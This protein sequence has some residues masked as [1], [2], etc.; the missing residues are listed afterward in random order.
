LQENSH[1]YPQF[2]ED[3]RHFL[4]VS[5]C[6]TRTNNALYE[7][8]LDSPELKRIM[9]VEAQVFYGPRTERRGGN[10]V[11]YREGA[12]WAQEFDSGNGKLSA[13]VLLYDK[14]AYNAPS[15]NASFQVSRDGRVIVAGGENPSRL[16]WFRR[17][18]EEASSVVTADDLIQLRLSPDKARVAYSRPDPQ[19]GN[20]DIWVTELS[21]GISSRLITNVANDWFPVWAPDSRRILFGSDRYGG[22]TMKAFMKAS[23]DVGS[24]EN[25]MHEIEQPY[26]WSRDGKWISYGSSDIDIAPVTGSASSFGFLTT[27]AWEVNGRFSPNTKWIAYT[28][29]ESGRFEIYVRPFSGGRAGPGGKVQ[30]SSNGGEFPVWGPGG[31]ELYFMSVD[32]KIYAADTRGLG[33]SDSLPAP[34]LLFRACSN[35]VPT[36]TPGSGSPYSYVFDTLDGQRFLVSCLTQKPGRFTVLTNWEA[37]R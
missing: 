23:L 27:S 2:L 30:I 29:D 32:N 15:V 13:P 26:D 16:V 25:A 24:E 31:K 5:R 34:F 3:G 28:S 10:I 19:T 9:P 35:S 21:R 36:S 7:S 20:R 18:G 17:D 22:T 11:F 14:V 6:A 4:F 37:E 12:L 8:S 1:R 33:H